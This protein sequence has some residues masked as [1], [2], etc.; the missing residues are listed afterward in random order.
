MGAPWE[1]RHVQAAHHMSLFPAGWWKMPVRFLALEN[2]LLKSKTK[3]N[4]IVFFPPLMYKGMHIF[5]ALSTHAGGNAKQVEPLVSLA[6][7]VSV[8]KPLLPV[9]VSTP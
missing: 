3:N 7:E 4:L 8:G 6:A 9:G 1:V 2:N 5:C